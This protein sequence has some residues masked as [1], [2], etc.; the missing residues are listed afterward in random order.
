MPAAPCHSGKSCG[1]S[2]NM[3]KSGS[4]QALERNIWGGA[5]PACALG[6]CFDAAE[7]ERVDVKTFNEIQ[8]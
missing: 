7:F 8:G 2:G 6:E 5:S 3:V 1:F 4:I